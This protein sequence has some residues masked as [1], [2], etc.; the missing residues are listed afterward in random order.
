[1]PTANPPSFSPQRKWSISLSVLLSVVAA[2]G[3]VLML[4]YLAARHY[5]RFPWSWNAR[6]E[7]APLTKRVLGSV[8][9]DVKVVVYFSQRDPLFESVWNLLKEYRFANPHLR[10]E[11][12]DYEND[13]SNANVVKAKYHLALPKDA[14]K[15]LLIFDCEG[16]PPRVVYGSELS[17]FDL[18]PL[19]SGQSQEVRRTQFKGEMLFTS[20]LIGVL[21]P[22]PL[23]AYFL[24]GHRELSPDSESE[25][26]G[27]SKFAAVLRQNSITPEVL[28]NLFG[29]RDIPA[30]CNLLVIAGPQDKFLPEELKKLDRYLQQGGRLLVL[31]SML[32]AEKQLGLEQLLRTWG[33]NVGHDQV[34]DLEN[35]DKSRCMVVNHITPHPVM[36]PLYPSSVL[37]LSQPRSIGV[38][39][40]SASPEALQVEVLAET[41]EKGRVL[42]DFRDGIAWQTRDDFTGRVPLMVA[43]EKGTLRGVSDQ[44]GATRIIVAGEAMFLS[45]ESIGDYANREFAYHAVNWLLGRNELLAPLAPWPIREYKLIVSEAQ[46]IRLRWILLLGLPGSVLALGGL[47]WL[48][49]QKW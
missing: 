18:Q 31:F 12:V 32:S 7:L 25:Q 21:N 22:R 16:R 26:V 13:P 45:N 30:D 33:V 43:V 37:F 6:T 46:M 14:D 17:E 38:A 41:G 4:N 5:W 8:T 39:T 19:I 35:S 1:M 40:R 29:E 44:R 27:F 3:L 11:A 49:R 23:K 20:A 34:I 47:V 42:K 2:L 15:N 9:N 36:K 28:L 24:A 48:R 10:M